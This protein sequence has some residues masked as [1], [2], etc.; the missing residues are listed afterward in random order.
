MDNFQTKSAGRDQT[1]NKTIASRFPLNLIIVSQWCRY[2]VGWRTDVGDIHFN[3]T[4]VLSGMQL[5]LRW[6]DDHH[7]TGTI[8]T[9]LH[10]W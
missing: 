8:N 4:S 2:I 7:R 3:R 10:R 1:D 5:E 9:R 6:M